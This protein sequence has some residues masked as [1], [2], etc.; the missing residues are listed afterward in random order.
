MGSGRDSAAQPPPWT[1]HGRF[2]RRGPP[3]R[4]PSRRQGFGIRNGTLWGIGPGRR[5]R[6]RA[7][8]YIP[9][10]GPRREVSLLGQA[11]AILEGLDEDDAISDVVSN[12]EG[13][14]EGEGEK[15]K[16][17]GQSFVDLF[18]VT[19]PAP[20]PGGSFSGT[21]DTSIDSTGGSEA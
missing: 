8:V 12:L 9:R 21:D 16:V 13:K 5:H 7:D 6:L 2:I 1:R 3:F 15:V 14:L 19:A 20:A 18:G 4:V 10:Q 11:G 17:A